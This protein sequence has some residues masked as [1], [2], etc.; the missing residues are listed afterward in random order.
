M[1]YSNH[2][3]AGKV[4]IAAA[5]PGD[6]ELLTVKAAR[7]LGMAD[8]ILTDRLVNPD[9]IRLYARKGAEII[10]VGKQSGRNGSTPQPSINHQ[11]ASYALQG[12][13]VVRLKGGDVSIFSN[14]LDELETLT[15]LG[16][17]YE[18][19]PGVT[20]A[21]GAAAYAGIP[22]TA[23][24]YA[25]GVRLLTFHDPASIPAGDWK[26]WAHT[27]DTLVFYMSGQVLP[28][29]ASR[30]HAAGMDAGKPMAIISQATTPFQQVQL[31]S[32]GEYLS[33]DARPAYISP[34]L[35]MIGDVVKLH[36]RFQ[37]FRSD[38]GAKDFFP[39]VPEDVFIQTEKLHAGHP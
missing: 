17:S 7:Y 30:L 2:P 23:R 38:D 16:I 10:D 34:T 31:G 32:I 8:V 9:I 1:Q 20:S 39:P 26:D 15:S 19:V 12:K 5:G 24:G 18:L 33:P 11:M 21:L 27:T 6:A 29:L 36:P 25:K 13:L 4:I 3:S 28:Q 35:I 37:W 22:L 14:V